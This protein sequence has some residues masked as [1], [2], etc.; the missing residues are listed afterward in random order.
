M[1]KEE[2]CQDENWEQTFTYESIMAVCV[3][4]ILV[5]KIVIVK[6]TTFQLCNFVMEDMQPFY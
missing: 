1:Q 6:F 5:T 4:L 2:D 3:R